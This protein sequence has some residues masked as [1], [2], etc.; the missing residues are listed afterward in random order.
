MAFET[1]M[2]IVDTLT[3][4]KSR[5]GFGLDLCWSGGEILLK[6]DLLQR[7]IRATERI[8]RT[9]NVIMGIQTN[10]TIL[11]EATAAFIHDTDTYIGLSLDGWASL[12]DAC[13]RFPNGT[14][15]HAQVERAINIL[16]A[17]KIP[18]GVITVVTNFN[19]EHAADMID[20]LYTMGLRD[21]VFNPFMTMGR[22][23]MRDPFAL[24][25]EQEVETA[26]AI[27]RRLL[28]INSRVAPHERFIERNLCALVR[29]LM[30]LRSR[31]M[32]NLRSPCAAATT[33]LHFEP[34]GDIYPCDQFAGNIYFRLGNVW[35]DDV[36][37]IWA[38]H[39]VVEELRNRTIH[40]I[41]ECTGCQ[42]RLVCCSGCAGA[43]LTAHAKLLAPTP[44]C[45]KHKALIPWVLSELRT[46]NL[47]PTIL[48]FPYREGRIV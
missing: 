22:G 8:R 32:C 13:R 26:K 19:A 15:S 5:R 4:C 28:D 39:P 44:L 29:N 17:R 41:P 20:W 21:A 2:K 48:A 47:D 3:H 42:W 40:N 23:S 33:F 43:A 11:D 1:A 24:S 37:S 7:I 36:D 25:T 16:K 27:I 14:G 30:F 12:H 9:E 6:Q 38:Y 18:F 46:R 34:N 31:P 10:A 45:R 35:T